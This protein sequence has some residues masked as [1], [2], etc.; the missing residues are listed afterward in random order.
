MRKRIRF[1]IVCILVWCLVFPS[2]VWAGDVCLTVDSAKKL[3]VELEKKGLLEQENAALYQL[4]NYLVEQNKLLEEQN[5]LLKEQIELQKVE[6]ASLKDELAKEKRKS[7]IDK[8]GI[9][10]T[11][12]VAGI[13]VGVVG[14]FVL[15]H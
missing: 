2:S 1:L 12:I 13:V 8:L 3:V 5:R 11:G 9:G 10:V 15:L 14:L 6:I 4:N 7:W